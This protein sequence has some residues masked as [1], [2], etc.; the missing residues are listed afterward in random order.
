MNKT[1]FSSL[2]LHSAEDAQVL[3]TV[4]DGDVDA[5]QTVKLPLERLPGCH[6]SSFTKHHGSTLPHGMIIECILTTLRTVNNS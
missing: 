3:V 5:L 6:A 1:I 2:L 4:G